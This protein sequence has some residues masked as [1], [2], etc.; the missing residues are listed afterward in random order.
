M[1]KAK[2][3]PLSGKMEPTGNYA[4]GYARTPVATRFKPGQSGNRKGRPKGKRNAKTELKEIVEKKITIRDGEKERQYTL[5]GANVL[6]HG[7]KGAKGDARS[8]NVFFNQIHK[9]GLAEPDQI[10]NENSQMTSALMAP[11]SPS[12]LLFQNLDLDLLSR[13]DQ[14]ELSRLAEIIDLGGDLTA[15]STADFERVKAIM[16][17]GRKDIT[18][19]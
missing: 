9:M 16:K 5:L 15:L 6:A 18:P 10:E 4:V 11:A 13:E 19:Q 3:N 17:K 8:A 14:A 7:V 12:E 1:G 2:L